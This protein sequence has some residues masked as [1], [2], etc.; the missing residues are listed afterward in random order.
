MKVSWIKITNSGT[1]ASLVQEYLSVFA[2]GWREDARRRK[3]HAWHNADG[4]CSGLACD[5]SNVTVVHLSVVGGLQIQTR[6]NSFAEREEQIARR[7]SQERV[8]PFWHCNNS[9]ISLPSS[10]NTTN[11]L[12]R[13]PMMCS[14]ASTCTILISCFGMAGQK[15]VVQHCMF[16][17]ICRDP[18]WRTIYVHIYVC[19]HCAWIRKAN[20]LH[21]V[22][23]PQH[24]AASLNKFPDLTSMK[25]NVAT[26][27]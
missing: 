13:M 25:K 12:Q 22:V 4:R 24:E 15:H 18:T 20:M 3:R 5:R 8:N 27:R 19:L 21:E 9:I 17:S 11:A 1:R 26:C 6:L 7:T 23:D 16:R 10:S 2:K 14:N